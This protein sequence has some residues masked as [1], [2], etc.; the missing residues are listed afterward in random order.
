MLEQAADNKGDIDGR[1]EISY[2]PGHDSRHEIE[3]VRAY[4]ADMFDS[5]RKHPG[6]Y[7]EAVQNAGQSQLLSPPNELLTGGNNPI[8]LDLSHNEGN[9]FTL[10]GEA[11]DQIDLNVEPLSAVMKK[12]YRVPERLD[13]ANPKEDQFHRR[14]EK[15]LD[16]IPLLQSRD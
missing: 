4:G 6:V 13:V 10:G 7:N 1:F 11:S 3:C 12:A 14:I 16:L 8:G 9:R 15:R 5:S 2:D